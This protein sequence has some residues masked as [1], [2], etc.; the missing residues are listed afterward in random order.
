V[1]STRIKVMVLDGVVRLEGAVDSYWQ[2]FR[3]QELASEVV[4]VIGI[5]NLLTVVPTMSLSDEEI[6]RNV[7]GT[8]QRIPG[9]DASAVTIKVEHG[10]VTLTGAVPDKLAF[11]DAEN[12]ALYVRGV[13]DVN[14]GLLVRHQ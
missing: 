14:N 8:L 5:R 7:T 3:A 1:D 13:I 4:G 6:G 11:R 10:I 9:L 2:K 12:V